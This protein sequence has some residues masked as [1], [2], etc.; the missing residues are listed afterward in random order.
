M[1]VVFLRMWEDFLRQCLEYTCFYQ[2]PG[3]GISHLSV[4]TLL[5]TEF[6]VYQTP[7]FGVSPQCAKIT[8]D[9]VLSSPASISPRL[10]CFTSVCDIF[11]WG[12]LLSSPETMPWGS[13][14]PVSE[15]KTK[16]KTAMRC[17]HPACWRIP[18]EYTFT[19][20]KAK[21]QVMIQ[22]FGRGG[23][24]KLRCFSDGLG[25]RTQSAGVAACFVKSEQKS[26]F[27]CKC[28]TKMFANMDN[29]NSRLI[30]SPM[31]IT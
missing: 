14:W 2:P 31:E 10:W 22:E 26:M 15:R 13:L 23:R 21:S 25:V 20:K 3:F 5:K 30:E 27:F 4:W 19:L 6:W 12:S 24:C 16:K 9:S 29:P 17:I 7:G 1:R 11:A 28:W 18:V 8:W